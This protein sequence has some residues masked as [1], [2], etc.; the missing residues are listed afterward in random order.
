M[1]NDKL[2][3]IL[4]RSVKIVVRKGRR[5]VMRVIIELEEIEEEEISENVISGK[6]K[7]VGMVVD[8]IEVYEVD[9][10]KAIFVVGRKRGR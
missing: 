9:I 6:R 10:Y 7:G 4:K 5:G 2:E 3:G 1:E 8:E